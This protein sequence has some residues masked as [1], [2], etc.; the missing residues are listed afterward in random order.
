M[1]QHQSNI[2]EIHEHQLQFFNINT[3]SSKRITINSNALQHRCTYGELLSWIRSKTARYAYAV[4]V[5]NTLQ[6]PDICVSMC[7]MDPLRNLPYAY[8]LDL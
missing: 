4:V 5:M 6:Q 3:T 8:L 7:A 1:N 2:L